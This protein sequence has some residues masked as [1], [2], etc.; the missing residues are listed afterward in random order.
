M[1]IAAAKKRAL[2]GAEAILK[3]GGDMLTTVD[4]QAHLAK[5]VCVEDQDS[6][7]ALSK[8]EPILERMHEAVAK[9]GLMRDVTADFVQPGLST[10]LLLSYHTRITVLLLPRLGEESSQRVG[11]RLRRVVDGLRG[12]EHQRRRRGARLMCSC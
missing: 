1:G 11:V 2:E 12:C 3:L 4:Q 10:A 8:L 6:S 9:V 7:A 5:Q